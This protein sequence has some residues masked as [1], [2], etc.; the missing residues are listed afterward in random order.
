MA[1]NTV[2][3]QHIHDKNAQQLQCTYGKLPGQLANR[4]WSKLCKI[5][6]LARSKKLHKLSDQ[7]L[8]P[9]ESHTKSWMLIQSQP[10]VQQM[11]GLNL[12]KKRA[13]K[14]RGGWFCYILAEA[15]FMGACAFVEQLSRAVARSAHSPRTSK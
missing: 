10:A 15:E 13:K 8:G 9:P 2:G 12:S 6:Q 4:M 11:P 5:K 3:L 1:A 7:D 14:N